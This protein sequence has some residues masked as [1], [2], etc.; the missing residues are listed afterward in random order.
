MHYPTAHIR[1]FWR[2]GYPLYALALGA[3]ALVALV[4]FVVV[5]ALALAGS[6]ARDALA[7][8][9]RTWLTPSAQELPQFAARP[10]PP[11]A[12]V[13]AVPV[14]VLIPPAVWRDER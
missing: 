10:L 5:A 6:R 13:V 2:A 7:R 1:A 14:A 11:P 12:S 4:L 8:F 9:W 3:G